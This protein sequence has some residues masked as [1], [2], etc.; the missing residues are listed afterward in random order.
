[1]YIVFFVSSVS[2]TFTAGN[3]I[4]GKNTPNPFCLNSF[5][6]FGNTRKRCNSEIK[7]K[8]SSGCFQIVYRMCQIAQRQASKIEY[9]IIIGVQRSTLL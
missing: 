7:K 2:K 5:A 1:V 4:D 9:F 3:I 8:Y 6:A